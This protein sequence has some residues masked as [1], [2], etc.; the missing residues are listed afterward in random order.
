MRQRTKRYFVGVLVLVVLLLVIMPVMIYFVGWGVMRY[1]REAP[2]WIDVPG[3]RK[4]PTETSDGETPAR[5]DA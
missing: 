2:G 4:K 1:T 3:I 5:A